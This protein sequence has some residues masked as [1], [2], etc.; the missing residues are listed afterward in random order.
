MGAAASGLWVESLTALARQQAHA[1]VADGGHRCAGLDTARAHRASERCGG[2]ADRAHYPDTGPAPDTPGAKAARVNRFVDT[3]LQSAAP[4]DREKFIAGLAWVDARSQTLFGKEFLAASAAEQAS[5]LTR[6]SKDGNPDGEDAIGPEFFQAIKVMTINGYYTTEIGLRQELGDD[7]V[8]FLPQFLGCRHPERQ[9]M[10][11]LLLVTV[12]VVSLAGVQQQPPSPATP[13]APKQSDRPEAVAG[14][15]PGFQPIFDGK[16]LNGW[17]G[18][19]D[20]LAGRERRAGRRDHAGDRHQE[21]HL[22]HLA[23]RPAEGL[24]AEARL[25]H[26]ARRQQR[27]QLPQRA[28]CP[29]R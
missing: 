4:A 13:Y 28:S 23:R 2:R 26:H 22:H 16:T 12:A 19:P 9:V 29:T 20:V 8:L 11:T 6:I 15:E 24:R 14:D 18:D 7:G 3:V 25:P 10:K 5:L 27:H 21:Q 1:H 17:E